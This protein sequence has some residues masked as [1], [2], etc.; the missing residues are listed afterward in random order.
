MEPATAFVSHF[1]GETNRLP[2]GR[3][4]RPHD[5]EIVAEGSD[6]VVVDNVFRKAGSWRVEGRLQENGTIVEID[7][8]S[9]DTPPAIGDTVAIAAKRART[10]STAGDR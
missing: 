7:V 5:I 6:R 3:H 9:H 2:D 4:I 8:D 1:V 10:F